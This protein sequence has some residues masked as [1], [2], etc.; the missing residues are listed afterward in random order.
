MTPSFRWTSLAPSTLARVLFVLAAAGFVLGGLESVLIRGQLAHADAHLVAP[1]VYHQVL[2]LHGVSMV[3]LCAFPAI[4]GFALALLPARV[5]LGRSAFPRLAA[6]GVWTWVSGAVVLHLGMLLG[7][8]SGAGMLGNGSMTSIEWASR[9]TVYR[10]FLTFRA[11]GVDW[12]ATA[13]ALVTFGATCVVL[14]VLATTLWRR[15]PEVKL[16]SFG[17]FTLN[18]TLSALLGLVAFPML[19][20]SMVLLQSDRLLS[21]GW[22]VPEVGADPTLWGRLTALLGHPQVSMMLTPA[23]G[24]ATEAVV[25]GGGSRPMSGRAMMQV[26]AVSLAG[27]GLLMWCAQLLPAGSAFALAALPI[28]GTWLALAIVTAIFAWIGYL[29]GRPLASSPSLWFALGAG[30]M[31]LLGAFSMLPLAL[32]PAAVRQVG[33][34]YTVAHAHEMLFGGVVMGLLAGLYLHAPKLF[35]R[36]LDASMGRLHFSLSVL[37]GVLTFL[38][39]HVLGLAGMPRR[40]H[41]YLPGMGWDR[42]NA[43]SS[44]GAIVLVFA[45]LAFVMALVR[46]KPVELATTPAAS[47]A[48]QDAAPLLAACGVAVLACGSLLG[49]FVGAVGGLLLVFAVIDRKSVV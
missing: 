7:G 37:G 46:S 18:G 43:L 41:T 45:G 24:L 8:T 36:A 33:T 48:A 35:G 16:G 20:A 17:G 5:A 21:T 27:A 6:F 28:A 11:N 23:M 2:T 42:M 49:W 31:T 10:G 3:F 4:L 40:I 25:I 13:M 44:V 19:C 38:P 12:W 34:Y 15:A 9:D 26:S 29:W 47:P 14:D 1:S 32:Q 39:M 22:F 30:V